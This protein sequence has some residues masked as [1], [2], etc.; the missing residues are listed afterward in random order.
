MDGVIRCLFPHGMREA[1]CE[2]HLL[3]GQLRVQDA[4]VCFLLV[5]GGEKG[6]RSCWIAPA[7][8]V[9]AGL[10]GEGRGVFGQRGAFEAFL[11]STSPAHKA[12]RLWC[13]PHL[14]AL[15]P[16]AQPSPADPPPGQRGRCHGV[17]PL[18]RPFWGGGRLISE[19]ALHY[20]GVG[21][22]ATL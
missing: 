14:S 19:P 4:R 7:F 15:S 5:S 10:S 20:K 16:A 21:A 2:E 1:G 3:Q 6:M 22:S 12:I 11:L 9:P 8:E 13:Q 17:G 18:G